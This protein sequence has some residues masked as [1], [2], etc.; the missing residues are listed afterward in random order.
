MWTAEK[1]AAFAELKKQGKSRK[2][3]TEMLGVTLSSY[4][5]A[6]LMFRTG[7]AKPSH[8]FAAARSEIR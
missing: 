7:V 1:L 8:P 6:L 2:Q 4:S 3:I 5:Y